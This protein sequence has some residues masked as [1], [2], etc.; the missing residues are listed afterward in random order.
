MAAV[1]TP[2][3]RLLRRS[4]RNVDRPAIFAAQ[5]A[6][7]HV[8]WLVAYPASGFLSSAIGL[9]PTMTI[10]GALGFVSVLAARLVWPFAI[11]RE[12]EHEHKDMDPGHP[13]LGDA[14][15]R[16]GAFVHRHRFVIDDEHRVWPTSG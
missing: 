2:A 11:A 15:R 14:V 13:H 12:L 6:L 9:A 5:F 3:G 4:A 1:Q 8:C 10:L 7:S 16:G